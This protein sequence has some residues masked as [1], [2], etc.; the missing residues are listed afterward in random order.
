M[1]PVNQ[2][3]WEPGRW[4]DE[5][6]Q[7]FRSSRALLNF[8]G[9]QA[10]NICNDPDFAVLVPESFA[11]RMVAGDAQD[12]LLRQVLATQAEKA[13]DPTF[14]TD[15]LAEQHLAN[16]SALI[17]KYAHRALLI[18][19]AGCAINCRYCF[20]RHFPYTEHRDRDFQASLEQIAADTSLHEIILSGG[21]PLILSDAA[22]LKL[23]QRLD[24][25]PHVKR[26]RL[27]TRLPVVL[28]NRVTQ[29]LVAGLHELNKPTTI[30]LHINHPQ[31]LNQE[32]AKAFANLQDS[33]AQLLNQ[34]VLLKGINDSLPVQT[35]LAEALFEQGVLPYY[36]HLADRVQGTQH[37]FV[38]TPQAKALHQ[39]MQATLPGYLVPR[40]A[41]EVP[42]QPN[43]V[44][45]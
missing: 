12:P 32:T 29:G 10:D 43:K 1:I 21:D 40:L 6:R 44:L 3:A 34:S 15:P 28:P 9:T 17:Q 41:Q 26:L 16:D 30:V 23:L 2:H 22:L 19:T 18:T 33:G 13:T 37:F 20:R 39:Q 5:L 8:L 38:D 36:L 42:A 14:G 4:Q 27:H 11:R 35:A 31:E 7:A 24:A 45:L 25:V